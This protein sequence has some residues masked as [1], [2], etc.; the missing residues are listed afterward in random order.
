MFS[1]ATEEEWKC[2]SNG[3]VS[4]KTPMQRSTLQI[5][6]VLHEGYKPKMLLYALNKLFYIYNQVKHQRG[7]DERLVMAYE[8]LG[9]AGL[10]CTERQHGSEK[11]GMPDALS[12]LILTMSATSNTSRGLYMMGHCWWGGHLSYPGTASGAPCWWAPSS[13]STGAAM[14]RP[15]VHHIH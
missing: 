8:I 15:T 6:D 3:V 4:F 7:I 13:T 9:L 2:R 5:E 10:C 1:L 11:Q 14:M 12:L